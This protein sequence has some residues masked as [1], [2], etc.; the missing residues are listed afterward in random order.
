M[1]LEST[2][3]RIN[4]EEEGPEGPPLPVCRN[5]RTWHVLFGPQKYYFVNSSKWHT[6]SE[7]PVWP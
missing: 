2:R 5:L 4:T 1:G 6:H 7:I 3:G